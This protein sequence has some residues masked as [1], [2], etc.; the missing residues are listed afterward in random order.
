MYIIRNLK[1]NSNCIKMSKKITEAD[2][3][4]DFS[5]V[6]VTVLNTTEYD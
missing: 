1:R 6:A 2:I 4:P 5:A 3:I